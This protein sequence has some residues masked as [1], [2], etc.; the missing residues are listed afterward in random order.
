MRKIILCICLLLSCISLPAFAQ[1]DK[2]VQ[3]LSDIKGVTSVF[4]SESMLQLVEGASDMI[5]AGGV[6]LDKV[7][8]K[9][10]SIQI[11]NADSAPAVD[12]LRAKLT[13]YIKKNNL[14]VLM[15]TKDDDEVTMIYFVESKDFKKESSRLFLFVDEKDE[16]TFIGLSGRF[17]LEDL[18]EMIS[19]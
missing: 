11:L 6:K 5:N 16:V 14:E 8:P 12:E 1:N 10:N 15:Q 7:I 13:G 9:L 19:K 4:I 3:E 2:L 18:K 17:K